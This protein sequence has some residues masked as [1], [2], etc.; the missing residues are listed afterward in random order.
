MLISIWKFIVNWPNVSR[1]YD[2]HTDPVEIE[3]WHN[4]MD[5]YGWKT[6]E[7]AANRQHAEDRLEQL[8]KTFAQICYRFRIKP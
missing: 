6:W 3:K 5:D 7:V 4:D 1:S 8:N 2:T